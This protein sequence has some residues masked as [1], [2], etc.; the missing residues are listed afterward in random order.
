M[1]TYFKFLI[2]LIQHNIILLYHYLIS[3]KAKQSFEK[4][5]EWVTRVILIHIMKHNL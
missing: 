1:I 4:D 3:L 5:L 2:I